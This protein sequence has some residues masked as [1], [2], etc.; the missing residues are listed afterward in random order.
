MFIN[1][2]IV[3]YF[4]KKCK[5]MTKSS[6]FYYKRSSKV[7]VGDTIDHEFILPLKNIL[8]IRAPISETENFMVCKIHQ[9]SPQNL[10]LPQV[11]FVWPII[12]KYEVFTIL[13][14]TLFSGRG[15]KG[16]EVVGGS[17]FVIRSTVS[18]L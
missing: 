8:D 14:V 16:R 7:V 4:H 5:A 11:N 13:R 18:S 3:I 1:E 6:L 10:F 15:K 9:N 12:T 17:I 2:R